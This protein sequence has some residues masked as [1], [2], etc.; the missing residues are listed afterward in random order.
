MRYRVPE[1]LHWLQSAG[2]RMVE[3]T[4]K[5]NFDTLPAS[6]HDRELQEAVHSMDWKERAAFIELVKGDVYKHMFYTAKNMP[7]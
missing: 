4:D 1:L 5:E 7:N 3:W 2:L 6:F